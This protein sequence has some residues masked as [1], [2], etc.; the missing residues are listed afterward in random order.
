MTKNS[1]V[2]SAA[3]VCESMLSANVLKIDQPG[4]RTRKS[5]RVHLE[6]GSVIVTKRSTSMRS[7][8]EANVL[9]ELREHGAPVPRVLA[10]DDGWLIQEDLGD[11]RLS[12]RLANASESE[13]EELLS[14]ALF[15]LIEIHNAGRRAKLEK[16]VVA[17]GQNPDWIANFLNMPASLGRYIDMAPP[18]LPV[19]KLIKHLSVKKP[20]LIKWDARPGNANV[21][22][23]GRVFWFDW[24]HCG[25]R[26]PLDDMA[27]LLADEYVPE[28]ADAE[29]RLFEEFLPKID[30]GGD[31]G[32]A[33]EYCRVF[34]T[35]HI[36]VRLCLIFSKKAKG[37]WWDEQ[38]CLAGDK[39]GVTK[40][41]IHRLCARGQRWAW[42][43]P[44][45][46]SLCDWFKTIEKHSAK[47]K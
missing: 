36:C 39:V 33:E 29:V 38:A 25:C 45:T 7:D 4:G 2:L 28:L 27:W 12:A 21:G 20:Q 46:Q 5:V 11:Q 26:N 6:N 16:R 23:T 8:L 31:Q 14:N 44:L 42:H 19:E 35:L 32:Y 43:S 10:F 41:A 34:G 9:R 40:Q 17:I 37:D 3:K 22:P 30:T 18:T 47:L 24:E 13:A 1:I 15:S